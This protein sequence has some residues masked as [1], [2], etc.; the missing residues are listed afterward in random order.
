LVSAN[1]YD[2]GVTKKKTILICDDERDVLL[3]FEL[4]LKSKYDVISVD[5][6]EACIA[7]YIKEKTSATK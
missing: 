6:G 3:L 2:D 4:V 7:M 5:S 1:N